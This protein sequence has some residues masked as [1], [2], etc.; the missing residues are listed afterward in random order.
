MESQRDT[1]KGSC[2]LDLL[3]VT[4]YQLS[5]QDTSTFKLFETIQSSI[6]ILRLILETLCPCTEPYNLDIV[7]DEI[8][9]LYKEDLLIKTRDQQR[10]E[11]FS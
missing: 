1:Q 8:R 5:T 10:F 3:R 7:E 9:I 6:L 2:N 11:Q 4:I